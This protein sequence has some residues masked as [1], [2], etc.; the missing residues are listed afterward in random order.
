MIM[1][2][3]DRWAQAFLKSAGDN[4]NE[5][6]SAL[7]AIVKGMGSIYCE[8]FADAQR[9]ESILRSALK[10]T[11]TEGW[12]VELACRTI[13]LLA[14]KHAF[15]YRQDLIAALEREL[16]RRSGIITVTIDSASSLEPSIRSSFIEYLKAKTKAD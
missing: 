7:K 1:F 5:S 2:S 13:V 6:L 10:K 11:G 16:N 3:A 14:R 9:L 12:G 4:V 15:D 8:G